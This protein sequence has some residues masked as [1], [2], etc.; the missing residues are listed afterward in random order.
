MTEST[1][2]SV[3]W[4][5]GVDTSPEGWRSSACGSSS[6]NARCCTLHRPRPARLHTPGRSS[7]QDASRSTQDRHD[8]APHLVALTGCRRI[9]KVLPALLWRRMGATT[10]HRG[11]VADGGRRVVRLAASVC[12]SDMHIPSVLLLLYGRVMHKTKLAKVLRHMFRRR[13]ALCERVFPTRC[14]GRRRCGEPH[15]FPLLL[16]PLPFALPF[17]LPLPGALP[18]ALPVACT[19]GT[20]SLIM[21]RWLIMRFFSL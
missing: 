7:C 12:V 14:G 6:C 20:M 17:A 21:R 3:K 2:T 1:T 19:C 11:P 18:G 9:M 8:R 4:S 5:P 10:N 16:P 13:A 15:R